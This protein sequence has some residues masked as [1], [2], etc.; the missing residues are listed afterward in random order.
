M[1]LLAFGD[2]AEDT[3]F[4]RVIW[5]ALPAELKQR[6]ADKESVETYLADIEQQVLDAGIKLEKIGI[7]YD[8]VRET[9]QLVLYANFG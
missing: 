8:P 6:L 1:E 2:A 4:Q 7:S 5:D 9:V 3:E